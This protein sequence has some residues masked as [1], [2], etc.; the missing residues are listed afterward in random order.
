MEAKVKMKQRFLIEFL[1]VEFMSSIAIHCSLLNV[2]GDQTVGVSTVRGGWCISA[3][4]T[5]TAGC[6]CWCRLV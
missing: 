3:V 2:S 5:V 6:L 1:H 4:V